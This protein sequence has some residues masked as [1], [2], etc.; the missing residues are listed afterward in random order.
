[1]DR[2][3]QIVR[4][5]FSSI[6]EVRSVQ[7]EQD[8]DETLVRIAANHPPRE[9]RYRVY[10]K[11]K[12]LIQTFPEMTFDFSLTSHD[13]IEAQKAKVAP[14]VQQVLDDHAGMGSV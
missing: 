3:E 7:I 14:T 8:G 2:I 11:Q 1:M 5:A 10:D 9:V 6:P 12:S 4:D 13:Q